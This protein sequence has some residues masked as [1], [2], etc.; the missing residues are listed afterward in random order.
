MFEKF[1]I[2]VGYIAPSDF[3]ENMC[4]GV[5]DHAD[6]ESE[7]GFSVKQNPPAGLTNNKS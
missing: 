3:L 2:H 6:Y 7:V 4:I 1:W 5:F